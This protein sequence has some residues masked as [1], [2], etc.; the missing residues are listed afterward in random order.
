[1]KSTVLISGL[2]ASLALAQPRGH[3]HGHRRRAHPHHEKRALVT[4]WVTETVYET[5][6]ELIDDTTTEWITPT[7][8]AFGAKATTLTTSTKTPGQF[9]EGASASAP[10]SPAETQPPAAPYVPKI[11]SSSP[12]PVVV[13]TPTYVPVAQS[14]I[15][16]SAPPP[17]PAT[18]PASVVA[19]APASV[20]APVA[21]PVA[22]AGTSAGSPSSHTGDLTYYAL[23]L[24][25]CGFDDSGK[26]HT[27]NIVALSHELMGTQSNGNPY[28]DKTITVSY[29]GK[30]VTAVVRDKCMGCAANNI[31]GSE[32]LFTDL[33]EPLGTGRYTVDWWFN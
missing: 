29:N 5:V 33:G 19:P 23:G 3:G 13:E 14:P 22:E 8:K 24:G 10:K 30:T 15:P 28:C 7:P 32:K 11:A 16:S 27:Q 9:F 18:S 12:A 2:L 17:A 26:D 31:D 21:K 25:A 1:M 20:P 6:T 4:D